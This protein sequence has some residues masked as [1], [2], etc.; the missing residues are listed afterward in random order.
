MHWHVFFKRMQS[1]WN[2][3]FVVWSHYRRIFSRTWRRVESRQVPPLSVAGLS[4]TARL[5]EPLQ[6]RTRSRL[7]SNMSAAATAA[8][9]NVQ[10]TDR[11]LTGHMGHGA[12]HS[13][14][15]VN[16]RVCFLLK[17]ILQRLHV[18]NTLNEYMFLFISQQHPELIITNRCRATIK[19]N[20]FVWYFAVSALWCTGGQS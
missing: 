1:S 14:K 16:P 15:H 3:Y 8:K 19:V 13:S 7:K 12:L 4:A 18:F 20:L 6:H 2:T 11:T 5:I 10:T 17:W 9:T